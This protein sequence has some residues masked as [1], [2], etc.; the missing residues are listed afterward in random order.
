MSLICKRPAGVA[1]LFYLTSACYK[2]FSLIANLEIDRNYYIS[3][4]QSV[5][6]ITVRAVKSLITQ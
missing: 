6:F 4:Q 1:F 3:Q 2:Q 5:L